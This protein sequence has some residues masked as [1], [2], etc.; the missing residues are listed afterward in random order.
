MWCGSRPWPGVSTTQGLQDAG[1]WEAQGSPS[2]EIPGRAPPRPHLVQVSGL[3]S[4]ERRVPRCLKS[5][6]RSFAVAAI[7]H[8]L[9]EVTSSDDTKGSGT[10]ASGQP[11]EGTV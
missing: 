6:L 11:T 8:R 9:C 1:M 10:R 7:G 3:Q 5:C 2:P 4:R